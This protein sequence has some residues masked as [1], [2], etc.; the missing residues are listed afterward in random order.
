ME[1][2]SSKYSSLKYYSNKQ[3]SQ[4]P[5]GIFKKV[6]ITGEPRTEQEVGKM[7]II[8]NW[9]E[10][11]L[12]K[13]YLIHNKTEINFVM[14]FMK[15]FR[16]KTSRQTSQINPTGYDQIVCFSYEGEEGSKS[17]TGRLCPPSQQRTD[18]CE[19]CK[20]T[21][22]FGGALL[23][24]KFKPVID[25][26]ADESRT[27]LIFF[28]NDGSKFGSTINYINLLDEKGKEIP[29]LFDDSDFEKSVVTPRRFV[30]SVIV[31]YVDTNYGR[32]AVFK[33]GI[34]IKL[35]DKA[36]LGDKTKPGI[37][38]N[39]MKYTKEFDSQFDQSKYISNSNL[40]QESK[41]DTPKFEDET[42]FDNQSIETAK[43]EVESKSENAVT[44]DF[45]LEI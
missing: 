11:D 18:F 22:I 13:K 34:K 44:D 7:Q 19:G 29:A 12:A 6:F 5:P 38:D 8:L 17:T 42:P 24:E 14:M 26:L 3:G 32:K 41:S 36:V 16:K 45:E 23:D 31:D 4:R 30:T 10:T 1:Q 39:C 40:Q 9:D 25:P 27:A 15:K 43:K 2:D 33:Y 28:Q 35:P 21:Y 37:M 20:F